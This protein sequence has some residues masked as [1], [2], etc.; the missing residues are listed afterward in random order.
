MWHYISPF[1]DILWHTTCLWY[2]WRQTI[3]DVRFDMPSADTTSFILKHSDLH[4][5]NTHE[6]FVHLLLS[7]SKV[8][9][10]VITCNCNC[11]CKVITV[12]RFSKMW[13]LTHSICCRTNQTCP[14]SM[15]KKRL[16]KITEGFL[17]ASPSKFTRAKKMSLT[18]EQCWF[19]TFSIC[20][21]YSGI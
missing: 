11:N 7:Q 10:K 17:D 20:L 18:F 15:N 12:K 14:D 4:C 3:C 21:I 2:A 16:W 5:V 9:T 19:N 6:V 8:F 13:T 1:S